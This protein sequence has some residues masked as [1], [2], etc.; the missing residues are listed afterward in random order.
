MF[1][2]PARNLAAQ[3]RYRIFFGNELC[4]ASVQCHWSVACL[5]TGSNA[6]V[7]LGSDLR[8][9]PRSEEKA[10]AKRVVL[11]NGRD[12]PTQAAA[13]AHFKAMLARYKDEEV[14]EDRADHEDLVALLERFDDAHPAEQS[15][16]GCG[17]DYFF[18]RFNIEK[19][20][21]NSSFWGRRTD[22]TETD[23]SDIWAVKGVA[24]GRAA[25][26]NDACRAAVR[27]DL[28]AAKKTAFDEHADE[29]GYMPCELTGNPVS[30]HSAHLDHAWPT[31]G[32][33]VTTFRA[34]RGWAKEIPDGVLTLPADAQANDR[35][36]ARRHGAG[37]P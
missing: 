33:L 31:F 1:G 37:L 6:V 22:G 15:K 4:L 17:I 29:F 8:R 5:M 18:R 35:V 21:P 34:A 13:L 12:W 3:V 16:N 10:M 27:A 36:R 19:G 24:K 28:E 26:F 2:P 20:F 32:M 7:M 30:I 11:S 9:Q 14:V 23:F 25:E